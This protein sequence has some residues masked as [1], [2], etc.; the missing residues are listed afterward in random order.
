MTNPKPS[1]K[2]KQTH[3]LD[4][5]LAQAR[6]SAV[7]QSHL[8]AQVNRSSYLLL[9]GLLAIQ[10]IAFLLALSIITTNRP[11]TDMAAELNAL[12]TNLTLKPA[13]PIEPDLALRQIQP[14]QPN[15]FGEMLPL[16]NS[17][18]RLR[19]M[20]MTQGIQVFDEPENPR[21]N[22]D[23]T[24]PDAIFCNNSMPLVAGR[25]TMLRVYVACE[26][27][28]ITNN[29][30]LQLHVYKDGLRRLTLSHDV[31]AEFLAQVDT[32]AMPTLRQN[33]TNS[34]NFEFMPPPDWFL[35][36]LTF[37]LTA[38]P[39][40]DPLIQRIANRPETAIKLGQLTKEF[41]SRKTLRVAYLPIEY[42][43]QVPTQIDNA[44]YWLTRM[45]PVPNVEYYRLPV[46]DMV[47]QGELNKNVI[48]QKLLY[49]YWLY[50]IYH[51]SENWPDQLF[52]WLPKEAYNGGASD[53]YWCPYCAG[54]HSSRVAFG[55]LRSELDIGG[56]RIMVHEVAHNLG[57]QHAWSPT[58]S[59]DAACFRAEGADI[60]VD[61]RWP[62]HESPTIQ[63]VGLDLYSNPPVIYSP[64]YYDMMAYCTQ[65][66]ISPYTY[67]TLFNSPFLDPHGA[68]ALP[69]GGYQP[70]VQATDTGALLISGLV[71]RDGT[72]SEPEII[73]LE[74]ETASALAEGFNPPTTG[75]YCLEVHNATDQLLG[76]QCFE[77]GFINI[78]TGLPS[79]EA[80][81]F[82]ITL[83]NIAANQAAKVTLSK[84]N[85]PLL[86]L[87]ASNSAPQINLTYPN[88]GEL[89]DGQ[90]TIRWQASDADEDKLYY[91]VLYSPDA[92]Q[93]WLPLAV[94]LTDTSYTFHARQLMPSDHALIKVTASDGFHNAQDES[95]QSF[96][97]NSALKNSLSLHGP[98]EV[99]TGELFTVTLMANQISN[100][101]QLTATLNFD[102]KQ[103][104][105]KSIEFHPELQ[106]HESSTTIKGQLN[107]AAQLKSTA[108]PLQGDIKLVTI[109]FMA[110]HAAAKTELYLNQVT[111]QDEHD[112]SLKLSEILGLALQVT[113][114]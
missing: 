20:E 40:P 66:W 62:Y 80:S 23:P 21:C 87:Q 26:G 48:L 88:G 65:P 71:Y 43:G 13:P 34:I 105:V 93:S 91:D 15:Q 114:K 2:P 4:K 95:D 42:Q 28:C 78:E 38:A 67:L 102:P 56:P 22:P 76:E 69:L 51:P 12:P 46:P 35:G 19:G 92:G 53:P 29:T 100:L 39:Q 3:A 63:E 55:G 6:A 86:T 74:G 70:Q 60:K 90:T 84:Q 103:L 37:E 79:E 31:S 112:H 36:A 108:Q 24:Q 89:L 73:Q 57:A 9:W 101:T 110:E 52:G 11:T 1:T 25:H 72:V 111:L 109:T 8:A 10:A 54:A 83:P 104:T 49:T 97:L 45:Y 94:R 27:V 106:E 75:D 33:L 64:S 32:L 47:W 16:N 107:L 85:K 7:K 82:F 61:P 17:G 98:V 5:A 44:D 99:K 18:L 14:P 77:V 50:A 41:V 113:G 96:K 30:A 81:S 68:N 58:Q 59:E